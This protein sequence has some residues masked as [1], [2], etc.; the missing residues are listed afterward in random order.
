MGKIKNLLPVNPLDEDTQYI[1]QSYD[2]YREELLYK[3]L[4]LL[5]TSPNISSDLRE[6]LIQH[7]LW[8]KYSSQEDRIYYIRDYPA[9]DVMLLVGIAIPDIHIVYTDN[10]IPSH[11]LPSLDGIKDKSE[12]DA[13]M[14]NQ[15]W[16]SPNPLPF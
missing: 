3:E 10:N 14:A 11:L 1:D 15:G 2:D 9:G 8:L 4:E 13:A 6:Y 5:I 16:Y 12:L 7:D